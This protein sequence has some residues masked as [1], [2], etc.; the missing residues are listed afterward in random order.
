M[1]PAR[2]VGSLQP[3]GCGSRPGAKRN[4]EGARLKKASAGRE[5]LPGK[6][7][8]EQIISNE[9]PHY[10]A[11]S[12][13]PR[14]TEDMIQK[15]MED[16][17]ILPPRPIN[18]YPNNDSGRAAR[19]VD[20]YRLQI[21]FVPAWACWLLW[22][23]HRWKRDECNQITNIAV[24]HNRY[25]EHRIIE[26]FDA[27]KEKQAMLA[28]ALSWGNAK[29]IR[30][31]LAIASTDPRI[32]VDYRKLDT[33]PALLGVKNGVWDFRLG[34]L[35]HGNPKDL[36]TRQV[37]V[38][39]DPEAK[40]PLWESHIRFAAQGDRQVEVFLQRMA[41]YSFTGYTNEEVWFF[42]HGSGHNGKS[43]FC[44]TLL[45]L[46]GDYGAKVNS[47][48]YTRDRHNKLPE[49]QLASIEG[50]RLALGPEVDEGE[51][52]A[53]ARI[54][55]LCTNSATI[56]G[57][58]Q[59]ARQ[60]PFTL[61]AKLWVYGN[62][63]PQIRG[64]DDGIWRRLRL[65]PWTAQVPAGQKDKNFSRR[66]L[67]GEGRGILKWI[68]DGAHE[69]RKAADLGTPSV[70]DAAIA[71]Y[72]VQE[73]VLLDF[74]EG[75]LCVDQSLWCSRMALS[76]CYDSWT[77]RAGISKVSNNKLFERMRAIPGVEDKKQ[78]K[79]RG[80]SGVGIKP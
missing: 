41:G 43:V 75:E 53:E 24:E 9:N 27:P 76:E 26:E 74:V 40:C 21:R 8:M 64:L 12:A 4:P 65:I 25:L 71:E 47:T 20:F 69:W 54:K 28:Q 33:D 58:W 11:L 49:D 5:A 61:M 34:K 37:M 31:M 7:F 30:D 62:H 42:H 36:I 15:N 68:L 56:N 38:E 55:E 80:F 22:D 46:A 35:R 60:K 51:R 70:V 45:A 57:R 44:D 2:Q 79:Q 72:R 23:G 73:D 67:E 52:L 29:L 39:Y 78:N 18:D 19:F 59:H 50:C 16:R 10:P 48:L 1:R 3:A 6:L 63:Y 17:G 13:P 77:T 66:L 32:V 14:K